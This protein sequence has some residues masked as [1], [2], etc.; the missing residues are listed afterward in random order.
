LR[1]LATLFL[2]RKTITGAQGLQ[3]TNEMV[4]VVAALATLPVLKLGLDYYNGWV[5]VILYPGAFRVNHGNADPNGLISNQAGILSGE[6]WLR[7]PVVYQQLTQFYRQDP[8]LRSKQK[9]T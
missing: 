7:G 6:A 2:R 4:V 9:N 5:K 1:E 8:F 3:V